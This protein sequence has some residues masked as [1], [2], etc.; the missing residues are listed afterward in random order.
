MKKLA[1]AAVFAGFLAACGGGGD[2]AVLPIDARPGQD[3]QSIDAPVSLACDPLAAPGQQGCAANE[4]CT[5]IRVQ[6]TP[7][8]I[9]SLGCVPDGTV[10]QGGTCTRGADGQTTGYDNCAAGNICIG[11]VTGGVCQDICGFDG[12]ANSAC[13]SGF[14]CTRYQ[15]LFANGTD[16]PIA[17][18]CNPTCNPVTQTQDANNQPCPAGRACYTLTSSTTTIAVCAGA[19]TIAVGAPITGNPAANSCVPF[20]A[21]RRTEAGA[22]TYECGSLCVP[23]DVSQGLNVGDEGGVAPHSCVDGGAAPPES[24]SAGE[25]CRYF[26][27]R[28]S[29]TTLSPFSNTLGFCWKHV[30]NWWDNTGMGGTPNAPFPRCINLPVGQ[31]ILPPVSMPA[32]PDPLYFWCIKQPTMLTGAVGH[33]KKYLAE[34][35]GNVDQFNPNL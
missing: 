14:A 28:E 2:D 35:I 15:N 23:N 12:G 9:G 1:F 34:T 17:G 22:T 7:T 11:P 25:S 3:A 24:A 5:W 31:D 18:A 8:I 27:A 29:F 21:P 10:A 19:G 32:V 26:W 30:L 4:K 6:S 13:A 20:A 16:D 33:A